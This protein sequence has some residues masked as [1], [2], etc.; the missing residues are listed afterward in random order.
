MIAV[1]TMIHVVALLSQVSAVENT[2]LA[3]PIDMLFFYSLP[4]DQ[5]G[6]GGKAQP[7]PVHH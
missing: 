6:G 5:E 2:R 3:I 4:T 7:A 1:V